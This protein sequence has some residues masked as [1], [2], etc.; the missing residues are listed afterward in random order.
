MRQ[1]QAASSAVCDRHGL[2]D[3]ENASLVDEHSHG[4]PAT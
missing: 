4:A 1:L 3:V 2:G